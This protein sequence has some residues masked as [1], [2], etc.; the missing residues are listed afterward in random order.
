VIDPSIVG[1]ELGE[2]AFPVDRSK[3]AELARAFGDADPVWHDPQAARAA[4]FDAVPT[5]PTVTVL[6]DHWRTG[7]VAALVD[8]IGADV[9]A[10][11]AEHG[12]DRHVW[13][14]AWAVADFLDRQGTGPTGPP[15]RSTRSPP[16]PASVIWPGRRTPIA[17]SPAS[18]P[19]WA[20]TTRRS[21]TTAARL[22]WP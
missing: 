4:G 1:R 9:I 11:G 14:L 6:V 5:P 17:A 20:A 19:G 7:G 22:S 18:M 13:Q 3:L 15:H 12:L 2:I 8:A 10:S 16:P 21:S